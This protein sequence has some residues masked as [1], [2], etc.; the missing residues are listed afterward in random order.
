MCTSIFAGKDATGDGFFAIARDEDF[1]VNNWNKYLKPMRNP[2]YIADENCIGEGVWQLGNGLKVPIP[3]KALRYCSSPDAEGVS[4]AACS[5]GDHY[6]FE[7]RGFNEKSVMMSATNSMEVNARAN[8]AD[9]VVAVGIE[10]SIILTLVL[11]QAET[12]LE[13]VK[14]LGR[15]VER[16]GAMEANGIAVADREEIWYMEI[17]SGHHWIAVR[18]PQDCYLAVSNCMRIRGVDLDDRENVQYSSG[19]YEFVT[20]N[21]L[22]S[23]PD[24]N[25]FD[26]AGAFGYYG[27][28]GT[29]ADPYYNVDRLWLAQH[30]LTPSRRQE[31]R[32]E[33]YPLFLKPD[34]K[35]TVGD[36]AAVLRAGYDGT[37][38]EGLSRRPIGVAR[39]AESHI[40]VM[41]PA[42]PEG[43][44]GMIWQTVGTPLGC[45][46]MP[47]YPWMEYLPKEYELGN[48]VYDEDSAYWKFRSLFSLASCMGEEVSRET[49]RMWRQYEEGLFRQFQAFRHA[50]LK[51]KKDY[52]EQEKMCA[53]LAK[54]YAEDYSIGILLDTARMA[55]E[56]RA[57]LLT[58]MAA[59]I[60]GKLS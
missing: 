33:E 57:E 59:S 45:P 32:K 55:E 54:A 34:K 36:I 48:S 13:A 41:D 11:P 28:S 37:P 46:Y 4:E 1:G 6:F 26:F 39:T 18:I 43:T 49:G 15:Y 14:L 5:I 35:I 19:L 30:L 8:K 16:Y 2:Q 9:P 22:L 27:K 51:V 40:M 38:L 3:Q 60:D 50:V 7:E 42:M 52:A 21:Q 25:Y 12:A 10:E 24:R 58:R 17:G 53:E 47:V 31:I 56:A 20:E 44:E 29:N 23:N